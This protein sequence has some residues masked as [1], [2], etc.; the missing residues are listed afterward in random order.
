MDPYVLA[1]RY[2]GDTVVALGP[3]T[4]SAADVPDAAEA[5]LIVTEDLDVGFGGR[6]WRVDAE[7]LYVFADYSAGAMANVIR[8]GGDDLRLFASLAR[9]Q[10][11]GKEHQGTGKHC[12][13]LAVLKRG[14]LS[15]NCG[16][17]HGTVQ[18]ILEPLPIG[19]RRA[20]FLTLDAWNDWDNGHI[21]LE[22]W[23]PKEERWI[24]VDL[25]TKSL[26]RDARGRYLDAWG[27]S[28]AVNEGADY[29]IERLLTNT[30]VVCSA[31]ALE[32]RLGYATFNEEVFNSATHLKRWLARVAQVPFIA[33]RRVDEHD[34]VH[35][36][37]YYPVVSDEQAARIEEYNRTRKRGYRSL[38]LQDWLDRFYGPA[39]RPS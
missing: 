9:L 23:H 12:D 4:F 11:H 10:V 13:R 21:L 26:F 25:D 34:R 2:E 5:P 17:W 16:A 1:K 24:L 19:L 18:T 31:A 27:L 14:R 22:Y 35:Y 7:G 29:T 33:T 8:Y 15:V 37:S 6:T 39:A 28:E 3:R 38:P 32:G 30:T 20:E 36:Q